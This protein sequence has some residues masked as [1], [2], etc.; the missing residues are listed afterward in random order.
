[1]KIK[2]QTHFSLAIFLVIY[3]IVVT[4]KEDLRMA[5]IVYQTNKKTGVRNGNPKLTHSGNPI[6]TH[7]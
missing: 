6:L 3:Y 1:M 4:R 7:P 5:A 2:I